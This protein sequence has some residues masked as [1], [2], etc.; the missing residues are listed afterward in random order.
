MSIDLAHY[1]PW[2]GKLVSPWWA[3]AAMVR[4]G[5][6][7]VFRR[8]LYWFVLVLGL[9][10]FLKAAF[11]VYVVTQLQPPPQMRELILE[12]VGFSDEA[13]EGQESGYTKFMEQQS[14]V[15]MLLLA[16]SGSLLVGADFRQQA[17]PFY[18]SRRIDRRHYIVGKILASAVLVLLLT[19][20]PA[21]LLFIEYGAF[22]SSFDYRIDH[23]RVLVSI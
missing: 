23:W 20:L 15:G 18:L 4:V 11:V 3:C 7:Q 5:L 21:L 10:N 2:L 9:G 6:A 22:T 19:T 17:L 12:R 13:D 16:F 8:K 1:H 14:L